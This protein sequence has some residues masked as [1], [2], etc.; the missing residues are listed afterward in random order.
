MFNAKKKS[1]G[2]RIVFSIIFLLFSIYALSLIIPILWA[3]IT[4]FKDEYDYLQDKAGFPSKWIFTNYPDAFVT[5]SAKGSNLFMMFLNSAWLAFGG[6]MIGVF[7]SCMSA[8]VVAKYKFIGRKLFYTVA[9]VILMLPIVGALPSQYE[10]YSN[11]GILNSPALLIIYANGMGFN[12]LI[13]FGFF[14]SLPWDYVEASFID[15]GNHFNTFFRIMLPQAFNVIC[16]LA[17]VAFINVW[18]DYNT[19]IVFLE[20]YPTLSSGIF[21]YQN[22]ILQAGVDIPMLF[23][24]IFMSAVPVIAL[25][26]AF[27]NK[28]MEISIGGGLKG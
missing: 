10:V 2:E 19:P 5:L 4:T 13:L 22:D 28:I 15:G 25:F 27:Q 12:F 23:A 26:V 8:Y 3:F 9:L 7:V 21:I 20:S 24:G 17:V 16:A 18:N 14:T 11:L 6:T 1:R